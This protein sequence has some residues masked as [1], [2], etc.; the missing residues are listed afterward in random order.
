MSCDGIKSFE[1]TIESPQRVV[2][3]MLLKFIDPRLNRRGPP[4]R[5]SDR[6]NL[7]T[8][9][10]NLTFRVLDDSDCQLRVH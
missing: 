2:A 8:D 7:G 4:V 6:F 1:Q 9:L 5:P 3:T 10:R